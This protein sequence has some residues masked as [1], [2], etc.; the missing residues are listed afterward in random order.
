[1]ATNIDQRIVEMQFDN[2]QFEKGVSTSLQ[3]LENLKKSLNLD[4]ALT[5]ISNIEK[6]FNKMNFDSVADSIESIAGHFTILGRNVDKIIDNIVQS[7]VSKL[8]SIGKSISVDQIGAGFEKYST[9][10]KAV[11][12]ITNATGKSV[13][14]VGQVLG[15]LQKY[16]DETSYDFA[17]MASTIGKFTSVGVELERAETAMEG[18]ANVA[19]VAGAGKAEANR[20]MYNFAQS[21]STGSVKLIDW[22]SIENANMATKEFKEELIKTAISLGTINKTSDTTGK[23]MKQTK[24]ATSKTAA[25]FKETAVDYKTFNETLSQGWL[26]SDVL[27]TTLERY[28][29]SSKGVGKTAFEAAQKALTWTDAID[30]I[31]D[32]V[33]SSWMQSFQYIFGDLNEAIKLW[34]DFCTAIIEV[35][36]EIGSYRNELLQGWHEQGGYNDMIEAASNVW[37]VFVNVLHLVRDAF[38]T[39]LP[40]ATAENLVDFTSKIKDVTESWKNFFDYIS[41]TTVTDEVEELVNYAK[42]FEDN[43]KKGMSGDYVKLFQQALIDA[44]YTLDK[45]GADGIFGTETQKALKNLQKELGVKETGEWDEATRKAAILS[46]KFQAIEKVTKEITEGL[47][48]SYVILEE[49]EDTIDNASKIRAGLKYE[50]PTKNSNWDRL[51]DSETQ[52]LNQMLV[53]AGYLDN[54]QA[55]AFFGPETEKALKKLQKEYGLAQTGIW[56]EQ[57]KAM[58]SANGLF[59]ITTTRIEEVTKVVGPQNSAMERLF[60]VMQGVASAWSILTNLFKLGA[61][62]L[63]YLVKLFAPVGDALLTVASVIGTCLISL[64]DFLNQTGADNQ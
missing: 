8:S 22:K 20:A 24:A 11:Q 64:N 51:E 27:I 52:L 42:E 53:Y 39:I 1:M 54:T 43:M 35:T 3:S 33:S 44:G 49:Y 34:T 18:I 36:D 58:V 10:T 23:I 14:E 45:Y 47:G 59:S 26:T 40:P 32:A 63:S 19:A 60:T 16:T 37:S 5:S 50:D 61:N 31:K 25:Q 2:A 12:T 56:D 57:T 38:N 30:A 6:S 55:T 21:L 4:D 17:E 62:V 46:G 15:K 13:E 7:A 29:D 28:A 41:V 48:D 9:Q